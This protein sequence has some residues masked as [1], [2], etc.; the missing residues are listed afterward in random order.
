MGAI[1]SRAFNDTWASIA[2][3]KM[4]PV[5][6]P[7]PRVLW[8]L[9]EGRWVGRAGHLREAM[10]TIVDHKIIPDRDKIMRSCC[11]DGGPHGR[12]WFAA[13]PTTEVIMSVYGSF[14]VVQRNDG[15][16]GRPIDDPQ[17]PLKETTREMAAAL[18]DFD[19]RQ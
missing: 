8:Q 1:I 7:L 10:Q 9:D 16:Q 12:H 6:E 14:V 5:A 11:F 4:S 2:A 17:D 18:N 13:T 19:M 15:R 3:T